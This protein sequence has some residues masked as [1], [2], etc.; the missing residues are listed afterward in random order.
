MNKHIILSDFYKSIFNCKVYKIALDA[1]CTCPNRDG[2]KAFGGCIFCSQNGSGDFVPNKILPIKEQ[3]LE[4]IEKVQK[5]A[6]G[7]SGNNDVK[8]IAYFQNFTNTYGDYDDLEK[9]YKESL[10]CKDVKGLAIATRPDCINTEILNKIKCISEEYFVQIELGLQSSNDKTGILINRQYT[11]AEYDYAVKLIKEV[12]PKIHL[13]THVIL[14]LPSETENDMLETIR[15][16]DIINRR[17]LANNDLYGIK[18]TNLYVLKNT[19]LETL[20]LQNKYNPLEKEEYY[21]LL[22]KCLSVLSNN[23]VIH[24][25]TGDPPKKSIVAPLW[26]TDKKRVLNEIN[27][28][29]K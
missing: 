8:Y 9:K 4:A 1:G 18:I 13:V 19:K 6:K 23:T 26:C 25:I 12:C 21:S 14:G 7:R 16:I 2:T 3:V 29:L 20:Y 5:K 10:S 24:R 11:T 28:F 22:K 17:Y 15:H 27:K